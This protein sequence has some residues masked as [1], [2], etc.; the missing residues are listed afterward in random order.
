MRVIFSHCATCYDY[1]AGSA[2]LHGA[3]RIVMKG[4]LGKVVGLVQV[5]LDVLTRQLQGV[6]APGAEGVAAS[7]V[8]P[9]VQWSHSSFVYWPVVAFADKHGNNWTVLVPHIAVRES[10]W[11]GF[12]KAMAAVAFVPLH[13]GYAVNCQQ[14]Q[15]MTFSDRMLY[16]ICDVTEGYWLQGLAAIMVTRTTDISR[17]VLKPPI[18]YWARNKKNWFTVDSRV[19]DLLGVCRQSGYASVVHFCDM[20]GATACCDGEVEGVAP[21]SS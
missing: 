5:P 18:H 9:G 10:R 8:H 3:K 15:G 21:A 12:H 20:A 16:L 7:V 11:R 19:L 13:L 2:S 14:L 4:Q 1:V 6:V 17:L